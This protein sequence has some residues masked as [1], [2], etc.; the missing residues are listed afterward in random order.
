MSKLYADMEHRSLVVSCRDDNVDGWWWFGGEDGSSVQWLAFFI[1]TV[2]SHIHMHNVFCVV[3]VVLPCSLM[4][5]GII[6][7]EVEHAYGTLFSP[8]K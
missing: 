1:S 3:Q 5:V 6:L 7:I 4:P 2:H 8:C